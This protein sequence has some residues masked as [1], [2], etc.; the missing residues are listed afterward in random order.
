MTI[1]YLPSICPTHAPP[2]DRYGVLSSYQSSQSSQAGKSA[3]TPAQHP[4][5]PSTQPIAAHL[6]AQYSLLPKNYTGFPRDLPVRRS[7]CDRVAPCSVL[8]ATATAAAITM[9]ESSSPALGA[10]HRRT[11]SGVK[12]RGSSGRVTNA[13]VDLNK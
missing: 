1:C 4:M 7:D 8:R 11:G 10:S 2:E 6:T 5:I 9:P 3:S 13:Y 12:K